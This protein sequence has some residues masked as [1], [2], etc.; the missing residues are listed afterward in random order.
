MYVSIMLV[1]VMS[2]DEINKKIKKWKIIYWLNIISFICILIFFIYKMI[3]GTCYFYVCTYGL[4]ALIN[5]M[6]MAIISAFPMVFIILNIILLITSK[7]RIYEYSKL[8][9]LLKENN[10]DI[11]EVYNK[12]INEEE[13]K[14][15]LNIWKLIFI[16][17]LIPIIILGVYALIRTFEYR[18]FIN[19]LYT[20]YYAI[21]TILLISTILIIPLIYIILDIVFFIL[22]IIKIIKYKKMLN[23]DFKS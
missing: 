10:N 3:T 17:T 11:E 14:T 5:L 13:I 12:Y 20:F 8:N 19:K 6:F 22:A 1:V 15:K 18:S 7:I 2:T 21:V 16:V 4:E 9:K 23:I